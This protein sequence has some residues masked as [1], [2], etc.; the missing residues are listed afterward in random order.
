MIR[1]L[2]TVVML[3]WCTH[4][5]ACEPER[6]CKIEDE[7][8]AVSVTSID[9]NSLTG[10]FNP[11]PVFQNERIAVPAYSYRDTVNYLLQG[12][13]VYDTLK[14]YDAS[15]FSDCDL[16]SL[17]DKT[18]V[19]PHLQWV[20]TN[21]DLVTAAIF[22]QHVSYQGKGSISDEHAIWGWHSD[23]GTGRIADGKWIVTFDDGR[24][25][26]NGIIDPERAASPLKPNKAYFWCV[27][28]WD[29]SGLK[30]IR[31]SSEIPFI[32]SFGGDLL[33]SPVNTPAELVK[34][35]QLES[36]EEVNTGLD[37]TT[38]FPIQTMNL[39]RNNGEN[40]CEKTAFLNNSNSKE[41]WTFSRQRLEVAGYVLEDLVITCE[42]L[43]GNIQ[44]DSKRHRFLFK[45]LP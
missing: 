33:N 11:T 25:V 22:E 2:F 18:S 1:Y 32:T 15:V 30:V 10:Q 45:G 28:T 42:G 21:D 31:S 43:T 16:T 29:K 20:S 38:S 7:R 26:A 4:F 37:I 12:D 44:L 27:W 41:M 24:L 39:D 35:W 36:A 9:L 23:L 34:F 14:N 17:I 5:I 3:V 8:Y 40:S 13:A 19:K 6:Y